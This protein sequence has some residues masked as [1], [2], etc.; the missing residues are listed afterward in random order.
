[1]SDAVL[2]L[3]VAL[4]AIASGVVGFERESKDKPA[5]LRTHMLVGAAS[6]LYVGLSAQMIEGS[7]ADDVRSDP[8]RIFQAVATYA[9]ILGAGTVLVIRR[10]VAG[11]TTATSLWMASALGIAMGIGK[12]LVGSACAILAW[13]VLHLFQKRRA[14]P[15]SAPSACRA[16]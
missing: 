15:R 6:A 14:R 12:Y 10:Q 4:A 2:L 3:R 1:M 7:Q 8:L 5:G 16:R 11:L 13:A 9:S